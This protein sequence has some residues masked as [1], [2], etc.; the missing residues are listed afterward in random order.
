MKGIKGDS[1][2]LEHIYSAILEIDIPDLKTK[3]SEILKNM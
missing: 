2:R 1:A 3:I